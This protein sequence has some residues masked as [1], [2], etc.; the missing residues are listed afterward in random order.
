MRILRPARSR[1]TAPR[2]QFIYFSVAVAGDG[3]EQN[4]TYEMI[5]LRVRFTKRRIAFLEATPVSRQT[6]SARY[7]EPTPIFKAESLGGT[8]LC[9]LQGSN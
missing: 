8:R 3:V 2:A 9:G 4:P 6:P 1:S 7:L 5:R